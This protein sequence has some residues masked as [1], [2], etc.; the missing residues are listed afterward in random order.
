MKR[1]LKCSSIFDSDSWNCNNCGWAPKLVDGNYTFSPD[2]ESLEDSYNPDWYRELSTLEGKNFW[3]LARN[4]LIKWFAGRFLVNSDKYLEVGCGTGFVLQMMGTVLPDCNV[5]ATEVQLV[6][7]RFAKKRVTR[8]VTF[9]QMD[10]CAIPFQQEFDVIGA[11]DVLEHIRDDEVAISQIINALNNSG[12]LILTV[13]QHM[14]LWSSYDEVGCHFRRYARGEMEKKLSVAGFTIIVS[15]S[16]NSFLLPLMLLSRYFRM[17]SK[18]DSID[19]LKELRLPNFL[20]EIFFFVMFVEFLIIRMGFSFPF[21]GSRL[22]IA[23]KI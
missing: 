1:C 5:Y 16:F 14:F 23:R 15:T 6:G 2:S 7:L 22:I 4:R 17:N 12:Y 3:F 10:A 9:S 20:N 11:F 21:G 18:D 13:P 19:V 8:K